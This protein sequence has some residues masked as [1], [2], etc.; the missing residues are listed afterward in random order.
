MVVRIMICIISGFHS[1]GEMCIFVGNSA[2]RAEK[3]LKVVVHYH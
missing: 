2:E 1:A 3:Y